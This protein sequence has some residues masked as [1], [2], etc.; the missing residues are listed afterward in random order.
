VKTFSTLAAALLL[1][2][3]ALAQKNEADTPAYQAAARA[4]AASERGDTA[5][6]LREARTAAS[7]APA[8]R[9][10]QILL[11][12]LLA[13]AGERTEARRTLTAILAA[14]DLTAEQERTARLTLADAAQAD[15]DPTAALQA[16]RPI[17][18]VSY[19][20]LSRRGFAHEALGQRA[21][22]L[23]AFEGAYHLAIAPDQ[24]AL[25]A[26]AQIAALVALD[27]R[28]DA[29]A[30]FDRTRQSGVLAPSTPAELA[31]LASSVGDAATARTYFSQA[32]RAGTLQG[33]ALLDAAY[34]AKEAGNR[35][36]AVRYFRG[37]LAADRA[38]TIQLEPQA[39]LNITS[40]IRETART[41][42]GYI[43][44]ARSPTGTFAGA[45]PGAA[46]ATYAGGEIYYRPQALDGQVDIFGRA[47]VT[48]DQ[49]EGATGT[50]TTQG[51][52]GVRVRPFLRYN[53]V[54]EA[55]RLIPIGELAQ[56][57]W[58]LRAAVGFGEGGGLRLDRS[59]WTE[60]SIFGEGAQFLE[61]GQTLANLEARYGRAF[62]LGGV[63][64]YTSITPFLGVRANYDST[65][66]E[67]FSIGA[68][69]GLSFRRGLGAGPYT[70]PWS[71][72]DL[73]LQYRF[74]L[75]GGDQAEGVYAGA[76]LS[77]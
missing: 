60:W 67:Q 77:Y 56:S 29:R 52:V 3:P 32:E 44:V 50:R 49:A 8:N 36:A 53:L 12:T 22:A 65:F 55:S 11:A 41:I 19:D 69:P 2:A 25:M 47:F 9:D 10:Y 72:I 73:T 35:Q 31:Y 66:A 58:L 24:R 42:G 45:A 26:R 70:A 75:V 15:E 46:D 16:L 1:A 57:D 5:S 37:A 43:S 68:G 61:S 63:R 27:R 76:T 62:R 18:E 14:G 64:D 23:A 51:Y 40:E 7:L 21:E 30:L 6:A 59:H 13:Q 28:A 71:V 34:N 38:G 33:T 4:H 39:R 48:L 74:G 20:L 54:F 17:G